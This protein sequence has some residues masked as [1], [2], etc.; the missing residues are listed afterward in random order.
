V[1][2]TTKKKAVRRKAT[3][4]KVVRKVAAKKKTKKP[5]GRPRG[6]T[7]PLPAGA[8]KA[9]KTYSG[10]P[11]GALELPEVQNALKVIEQVMS[12][13][14]TGRWLQSRLQAAT[15]TLE[16]YA[17]KPVKRT[18]LDTGPTLAELLAKAAE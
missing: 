1:A 2:R 17:G 10:V 3:K 8:V 13:K 18:E 14:I 5:R 6:S 4:K 9:I 7:S 16:F 15:N 11:E 12:G